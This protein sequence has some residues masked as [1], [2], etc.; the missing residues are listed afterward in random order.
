M[1]TA[2][3]LSNTVQRDQLKRTESECDIVGCVWYQ[4]WVESLLRKEERVIESG[5]SK[6]IKKNEVNFE[7]S[8][9]MPYRLAQL[10]AFTGSA[11]PSSSG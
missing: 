4:E 11:L 3:L 8:K 6:R 10:P 1:L 2:T 7:D 9:L 5:M